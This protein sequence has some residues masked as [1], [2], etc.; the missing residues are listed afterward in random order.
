MSVRADLLR[1][2]TPSRTR[3]GWY[4]T[5]QWEVWD[6]TDGTATGQYNESGVVDPKNFYNVAS[7]PQY[8]QSGPLPF[9]LYTDFRVIQVVANWSYIVLAT[10]ASFGLFTGGPRALIRAYNR[11]RYVEIP[12]WN[13]FTDGV[14]VGWAQPEKRP[15]YPR[16]VAIRIE[17]RFLAGNQ[18]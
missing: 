16:M 9:T 13:R 12:I 1:A 7:L 4:G 14:V 6:S 18:V 11:T 15:Q 2:M 17:P 8:G 3:R 5:E 10:Y